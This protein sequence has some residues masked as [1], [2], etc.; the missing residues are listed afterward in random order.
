MKHNILMAT[1]KVTKDLLKI[2][3]KQEKSGFLGS[4]GLR[5]DDYAC[6]LDLTFQTL[7]KDEG[8]EL[9]LVANYI[10]E[11]DRVDETSFC[12]ERIADSISEDI[13]KVSGKWPVECREE[14]E[15]LYGICISHNGKFI[16]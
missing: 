11:S 5:T 4:V 7:E 1:S 15:G 3:E 9:C 12:F 6:T 14:L 16:Y 2:K 8:M 10:S 13:D